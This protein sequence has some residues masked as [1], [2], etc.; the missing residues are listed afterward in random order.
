MN[1]LLNF[2]HD[3]V[4]LPPRL[5]RA[6]ADARLEAARQ[7]CLDLIDDVGPDSRK[8]LSHQLIKARSTTDLRDLRSAL[9]ACVSLSHGQHVAQAR[10]S[11]LD[12]LLR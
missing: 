5:W 7:L 1:A 9:F 8:R 2:V 10:V 3:C 4:T 6:R 11:E 12:A